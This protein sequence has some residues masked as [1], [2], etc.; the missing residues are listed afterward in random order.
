[1]VAQSAEHIAALSEIPSR[2]SEDDNAAAAADVDVVFT[3]VACGSLEE[4]H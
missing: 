4:I 3:N 1:M 2:L